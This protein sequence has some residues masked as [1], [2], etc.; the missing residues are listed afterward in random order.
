M[1]TLKNGNL[2]LNY[3]RVAE[4]RFEVKVL[5]KKGRIDINYLTDDQMYSF[6]YDNGY[7][8]SALHTTF[9]ELW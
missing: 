5:T 8:E 4:N 1:K 2:L 9:S 3:D 7:P 6:L